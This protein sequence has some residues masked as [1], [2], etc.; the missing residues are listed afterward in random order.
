MGE[1]R[2]DVS[3]PTSN[4]TPHLLL[5]SPSF[6]SQNFIPTNSVFPV[7]RRSNAFDWMTYKRKK[8]L[9]KKK[10]H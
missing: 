10:N 6:L 7:L 9:K 2:E 3:H 4:N 1:P 8:M 5:P